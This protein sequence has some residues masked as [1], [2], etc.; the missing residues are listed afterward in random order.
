MNLR[1]FFGC[2]SRRIGSLFAIGGVDGAYAV[3]FEV[4]IAITLLGRNEKLHARVLTHRRLWL[5][6]LGSQ[7][8]ATGEKV[9]V[10]V[11]AIVGC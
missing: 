7:E 1:Q 4:P 11:L 5:V 10:E 2:E 3:E 6:V 8:V 9:D